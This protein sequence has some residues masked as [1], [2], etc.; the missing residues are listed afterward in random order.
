VSSRLL[1]SI[2][3]KRVGAGVAKAELDCE[4]ENETVP[5]VSEITV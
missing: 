1:D 2:E 5:R 4:E 3:E